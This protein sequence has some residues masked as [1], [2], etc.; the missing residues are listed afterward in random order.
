MEINQRERERARD[1]SG[2]SEHSDSNPPP[3][4][5]VVLPP[6][7]RATG[8][9]PGVA[10]FK[11]LLIPPP[12]PPPSCMHPR[13]DPR[14]HV[15]RTDTCNSAGRWVRAP[16]TSSAGGPA[17][18]AKKEK[19]AGLVVSGHG[20]RSLLLLP[21]AESIRGT[22]DTAQRISHVH[23]T[24]LLRRKIRTCA[25][26]HGGRWY[27]YDRA[28][29]WRYTVRAGLAGV[30]VTAVAF[31]FLPSTG[32]GRRTHGQQRDDPRG[33]IGSHRLGVRG[34]KA[35]GYSAYAALAPSPA[36]RAVGRSCS[37]LAATCAARKAW[38]SRTRGFHLRRR[39]FRAATTTTTSTLQINNHAFL[40][41]IAEVSAPLSSDDD[42]AGTASVTRVCCL[43]GWL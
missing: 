37:G 11:R 39:Q 36:I 22:G 41:A 26:I 33:R 4:K 9:D 27:C 28:R 13:S 7:F 10:G 1:Y 6:S 5:T 17:R 23:C 24:V 34:G 16:A 3:A 25:P 14:R 20:C 29:Q 35:V 38:P 12:V 40:V 32:Q 15:G 21:E 19:W 18:E 31:F 2:G 30:D 43:P 42:G 8:R